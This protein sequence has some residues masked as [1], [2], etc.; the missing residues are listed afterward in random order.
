MRKHGKTDANHTEIVKA[1]RQAGCS[2]LSMANLGSGAPDL[3]VGHRGSNFVFEVKD[4]SLPPSKR[5]L[6]PDEMKW[7]SA[8]RGA[9]YVVNSVADALAVIGA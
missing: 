1:L 4:G 5:Q 2:V 9:V 8:W 7:I 6:T 3:L